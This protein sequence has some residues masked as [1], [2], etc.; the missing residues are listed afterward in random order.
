MNQ[1][2][3]LH[4]VIGASGASGSAV[5]RALLQKGKR[6]RTVN[7]RKQ[8]NLSEGIEQVQGDITDPAQ[9]RLLCQEASVVYFCANAPYTRWATDFPPLLDG[10]I[11]GTASAGAKLVFADNLYMYGEVESPLTEDLPTHPASRK[12]KVRAQ[13]AKTLLEAHKSGKVRAT[14]GRASDY[15]GPGVLGSITGSGLFGAVL[16]GKVARWPGR[17]D[18]PHSLTFIDDF[19]RGLVMLGEREEAL[20]EVWHIPTAEPLTGEQ[21]LQ[22]VFEEAGLPPK[23]GTYSRPV[24]TIASWFSPMTRETLEMLYQFERPFILDS[25]KY[26]N[27]FGDLKPTAHREAIGQTLEWYRK[28]LGEADPRTGLPR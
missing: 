5:V 23:I 4:V 17:L 14:I 2:Q 7:R 15:Y 8:S 3:E 28:Y 12:G 25:S 21:F 18:V 22:M 11:E 27:T 26:C 9:A 6:V 19:A 13:M 10:A 24:V 16:Q 1:E 20:G